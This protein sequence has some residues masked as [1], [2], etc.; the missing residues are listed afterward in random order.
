MKCRVC[1]QELREPTED[2]HHQEKSPIERD[3][4]LGCWVFRLEF[5][6]YILRK[7]DRS[8]WTLKA[9]EILKS[10]LRCVDRMDDRS[11]F[12]LERRSG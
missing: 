4:C 3:V 2:G 9:D 7:K 5:E 6:K 1:E 8:M 12:G 10:L 11:D